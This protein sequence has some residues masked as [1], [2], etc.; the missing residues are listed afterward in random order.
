MFRN[1]L[2]AEPSVPFRPIPIRPACS[3][4]NKRPEWSGASDIQI[5][6]SKVKAGKVDCKRTLGKGWATTADAAVTAKT[7]KQKSR[8]RF[9][10]MSDAPRREVILMVSFF[11]AQDG[12]F[13]RYPVW[14]CPAQI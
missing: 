8:I 6:R 2:V 14:E 3:R 1:S 11:A 9:T 13:C 5:G 4:M 7:I 12:R 10:A